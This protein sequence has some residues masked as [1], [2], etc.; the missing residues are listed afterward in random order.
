VTTRVLTHIV[1]GAG[2]ATEAG[3]LVKLAQQ[4]GWTVQL[5]ATPTALDF[6]DIPALEALTGSPVRSHYRKP[7]EPRSHPADAI[8]VA[9][10]TYNTINKWANGISDTYALGI[11]AETTGLGVPTV[12]LP[13]VNTALAS[14]TPFRKSIATLRA[15]S[16]YILLGDGGVE[17]H[18]PH[19]GG[20]LILTY[21]WHYALDRVEKL[22]NS[23]QV[24]CPTNL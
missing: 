1:C 2:P 24:S 19:T 5:V 8:I 20:D 23:P 7:G 3:Q 15:E 22:I 12:V 6:L 11:L 17:P 18:E 21:P 13:F 14:R 4:R 16:I 9:P 10:A